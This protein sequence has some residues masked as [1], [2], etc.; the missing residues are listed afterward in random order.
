MLN[1]VSSD[2]AYKLMNK[3][4]KKEM[5]YAGSSTADIW[6]LHMESDEK[7]QMRRYAFLNPYTSL[8]R[9]MGARVQI[10]EGTLGINRTNENAHTRWFRDYNIPLNNYWQLPY[11]NPY[12][13]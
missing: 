3:F 5:Q 2:R 7:E 9:A 13:S 1:T 12:L 11:L 8:G 4:S 6:N 10:S